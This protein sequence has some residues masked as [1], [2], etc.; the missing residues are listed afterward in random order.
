M[1]NEYGKPCK[2]CD[3]KDY[4]YNSGKTI[5]ADGRASEG[6]QIAKI[7]FHTATL[8]VGHMVATENR[9]D[10]GHRKDDHHNTEWKCQSELNQ[11]I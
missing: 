3:C 9:C 10:C 11:L 1:G 8:F 5:S 2:H 4:S 7:A 6:K